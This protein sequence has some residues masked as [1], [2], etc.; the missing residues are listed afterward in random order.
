[1]SE[2][3]ECVLIISFTLNRIFNYIR[4]LNIISNWTYLVFEFKKNRLPSCDVPYNTVHV[5][6]YMTNDNRIFEFIFSNGSIFR[7]LN[8]FD[9]S[10][11]DSFPDQNPKSK[12][13]QRSNIR[14]PKIFSISIRIFVYVCNRFKAVVCFVNLSFFIRFFHSVIS[15]FRIEV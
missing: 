2:H 13:I 8:T 14:L 7:M 9:Y 10:V 3:W 11:I 12:K 4:L 1:M 6:F 5:A 15:L